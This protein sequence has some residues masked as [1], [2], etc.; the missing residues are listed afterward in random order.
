[1][2]AAVFRSPPTTPL[3]EL[4]QELNVEIAR[5]VHT[6]TAVEAALIAGGRAGPWEYY[7]M[8]AGGDW[9]EAA[10][11]QGRAK[12]VEMKNRAR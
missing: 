4:Y 11:L 5:A 12:L 10:K 9:K 1:M 2:R 7:L 3:E 8:L 6:H